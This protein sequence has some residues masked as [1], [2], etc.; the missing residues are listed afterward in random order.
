MIYVN[1][2]EGYSASSRDESETISH[3]VNK[4]IDSRGGKDNETFVQ[5]EMKSSLLGG[6]G[7][8]WDF[9]EE[10]DDKLLLVGK[11]YGSIQ[12]YRL[13]RKYKHQIWSKYNKIAVVY[14]D[15]H[16]WFKGQRGS[17]D[18]LE[19]PEPEKWHQHNIYQRNKR[20]RGCRVEG[21]ANT[22]M[23]DPTVDHFNIVNTDTVFF[24]ID[25][26]IDFLVG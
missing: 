6:I 2:I 16:S 20:P 26:A 10:G 14:V 12:T 24:Y 21:I 11:S 3:A 15:P 13:I 25:D 23:C 1:V 9:V 17:L 8:A 19:L 22:Q 7:R 4:V 18:R 5:N